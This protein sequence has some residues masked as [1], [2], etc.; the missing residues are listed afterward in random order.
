[1]SSLTLPAPAKINLFF[2]VLRRRSD[3]FH[4]V[5]S[6]TVLLDLSDTLTLESGA[7]PESLLT[8]RV[9]GG[10]SSE[11]LPPSEGHNLVVK[12][13]NRFCQA[14][15]SPT[16]GPAFACRNVLPEIQMTLVKRIPME[17]G[18]GGG[19]S[20]AATA[21]LLLNRFCGYPFTLNELTAIASG[22]GSDVPLFL[23][24][25][26]ATLGTGRGELLH[27]LPEWQ[28]PQLTFI[29]LKPP[30]GL[31][32]PAVY[33]GWDAHARQ[34]PR[35]ADTFLAAWRSCD[36][37]SLANSCYN[38]LEPIADQIRPDLVKY[39]NYLRGQGMLCVRMTGSGTCLYALCE[40]RQS[41]LAQ[42]ARLRAAFPEA[43]VQAASMCSGIP[44]WYKGYE[45]KGL[46]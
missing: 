12:A 43:Y 18:L 35:T 42:V 13:Y 44:L 38:G 29:L 17:A 10:L 8:Q 28:G 24:T 5:V 7:R 9:E 39:K 14:L 46:F 26:G 41:A 27:P 19:S 11:S 22:L 15:G 4:D 31:A 36:L 2:E 32:T 45:E 21:L 34:D 25:H 33:R 16:G 23:A 3:G 30:F 1:M 37:T 40:S 6:I 20:D